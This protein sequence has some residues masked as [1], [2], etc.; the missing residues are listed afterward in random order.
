MDKGAHKA[1]MVAAVTSGQITGVRDLQAYAWSRGWTV[2]AMKPGTTVMPRV[3]VRAAQA[4]HFQVMVGFS[5]D[6]LEQHPPG[7]WIYALIGAQRCRI[8]QTHE[9]LRHLSRG[10][11]RAQDELGEG[12]TAVLLEYRPRLAAAGQSARGVAH[13]HSAWVTAARRAGFDVVGPHTGLAVTSVM[14][15]WDKAAIAARALPLDTVL[16]T[17]PMVGRYCLNAPERWMDPACA[18]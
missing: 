11:A 3:K 1:A 2:R 10:A 13:V 14:R 6:A 17:S 18:P 9:V 5:L 15:R 7:V 8:G 16:S 12:V 4:A